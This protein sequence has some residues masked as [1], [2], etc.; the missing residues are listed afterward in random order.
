[1]MKIDIDTLPAEDAIQRHDR[2]DEQDPG[3]Q[4]ALHQLARRCGECGQP[5]PHNEAR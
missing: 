4:D 1:M 5:I 3:F 2:V